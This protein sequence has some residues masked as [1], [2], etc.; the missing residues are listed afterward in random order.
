MF[1]SAFLRQWRYGWRSDR[2]QVTFDKQIGT[3]SLGSTG[4]GYAMRVNGAFLWRSA[5][6]PDAIALA[7]VQTTP[8]NDADLVIAWYFTAG[9]G[10]SVT[11]VA[12]EGIPFVSSIINLPGI[13]GTRMVSL[14]SPLPPIATMDWPAEARL[15]SVAGLIWPQPIARHSRAASRRPIWRLRKRRFTRFQQ[16]ILDQAWCTPERINVT[17]TLVSKNGNYE[18]AIDLNNFPV[19]TIWTSIGTIA[20]RSSTGVEAGKS[21]YIA[22]TAASGATKVAASSDKPAPQKYFLRIFLYVNGQ[23]VASQV[24][25]DYWFL[26]SIF[27]QARRV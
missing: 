4:V 23:L 18:L 16:H 8:P 2:R 26:R 24:K 25:E 11:N 27:R 5:I 10:S 20:L 21:Y 15:C 6:D 7:A 22:A 17:Q 19:L 14:P 13:P 1:A 9:S 3:F 12:V